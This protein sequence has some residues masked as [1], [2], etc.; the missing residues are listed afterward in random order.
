MRSL[1]IEDAGHDD[2]LR[3]SVEEPFQGVHVSGVH[4]PYSRILVSREVLTVYQG[5]QVALVLKKLGSPE[6]RREREGL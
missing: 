6:I 3:V 2:A 5:D 4:L 1:V